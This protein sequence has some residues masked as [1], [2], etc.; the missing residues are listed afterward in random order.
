MYYIDLVLHVNT[1]V[2]IISTHKLILKLQYKHSFLQNKIWYTIVKKVYSM[3]YIVNNNKLEIHLS[4]IQLPSSI[5]KLHYVYYARIQYMNVST[6]DAQPMQT[7]PHISTPITYIWILPR[8]YISKNKCMPVHALIYV[9]FHTGA[10]LHTHPY[11]HRSRAS[12]CMHVWEPPVKVVNSGRWIYAGVTYPHTGE[13][14]WMSVTTSDCQ[15][16]NTHGETRG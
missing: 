6:I 10:L 15:P 1:N 11:Y 12:E 14:C 13:I 16:A 3:R 2:M 7:T 8:I 9:L 5:D 4:T